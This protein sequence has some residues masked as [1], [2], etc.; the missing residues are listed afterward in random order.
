MYGLVTIN[1]DVAELFIKGIPI[2]RLNPGSHEIPNRPLLVTTELAQ[3]L[4][5]VHP[6]AFV[7]FGFEIIMFPFEDAVVSCPHNSQI[8]V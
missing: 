5:H 3:E 7:A 8:F 6:T 2:Q 1:P 4:R